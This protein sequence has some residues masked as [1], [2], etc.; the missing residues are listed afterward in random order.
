MRVEVAGC[1]GVGAQEWG[2]EEG[3]EGGEF[4]VERWGVAEEGVDCCC[5][6][7]PAALGVEGVRG[8]GRRG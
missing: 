6:G 4:G 5:R 8:C 1:E 2:G 7:F 3:L